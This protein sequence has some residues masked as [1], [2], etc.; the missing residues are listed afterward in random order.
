MTA[1][2]EI[3]T[4]ELGDKRHKVLILRP[5]ARIPR[6]LWGSY[7]TWIEAEAAR[8]AARAYL[9]APD[10]QKPGI[11][12]RLVEEQEA[13]MAPAPLYL[14]PNQA[15]LARAQG[16]IRKEDYGRTWA[17]RGL[18]VGEAVDVAAYL[19]KAGFE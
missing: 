1:T 11:L 8:D 4:Y 14:L 6:S 5:G 17:F 7:A 16:L 13:A 15:A 2:V 18:R 9:A 19:K 10:D 12:D 3:E